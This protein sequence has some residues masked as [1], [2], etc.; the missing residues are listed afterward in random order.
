MS[1]LARCIGMDIF[2]NIFSLFV[3]GEGFPL[4]GEAV[5]TDRRTKKSRGHGLGTGTLKQERK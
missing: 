5:K 1:P 2:I 3:P 4:P